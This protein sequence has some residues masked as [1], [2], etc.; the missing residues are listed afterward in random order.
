MSVFQGL[1]PAVV[2]E[3]S[4]L[5]L[6]ECL[7]HGGDIISKSCSTKKKSPLERMRS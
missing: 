6:T 1:S 2:G 5:D 4:G 7:L 3:T